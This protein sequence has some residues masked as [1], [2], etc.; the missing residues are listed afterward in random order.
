MGR[1]QRA[2]PRT[3]DEVR[4]LPLSPPKAGL[5]CKFV[6][7]VIKNQLKSNKHCYKVSLCENVQQQS[8]SWTTSLSNSVPPTY[9]IGGKRSPW[10]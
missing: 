10:I 5:K 6:I 9:Y 1:R 2:F 7:F 8:F 3:I 4:T